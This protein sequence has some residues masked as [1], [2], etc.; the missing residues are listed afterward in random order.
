MPEAESVTWRG[1]DTLKRFT[2][3]DSRLKFWYMIFTT[4]FGFVFLYLVTKFFPDGVVFG[5]I[6]DSPQ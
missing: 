5:W 2:V 1:A 6:D 3:V 4:A